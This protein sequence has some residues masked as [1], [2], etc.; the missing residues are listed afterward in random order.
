MSVDKHMFKNRLLIKKN[1]KCTVK[2]IHVFV[3]KEF[4][5]CRVL[6]VN[7]HENVQDFNS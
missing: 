5:I 2:Q 6:L 4:E 3:K 1:I 7:N